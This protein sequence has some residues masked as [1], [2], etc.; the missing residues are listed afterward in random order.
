[1]G[2]YLATC[3]T[4]SILFQRPIW[5]SLL[6]C[7]PQD[8]IVSLTNALFY[9]CKTEVSIFRTKQCESVLLSEGT[10]CFS[11]RMWTAEGDIQSLSL[12]ISCIIDKC[13]ET[14]W[15]HE[16]LWRGHLDS[17]ASGAHSCQRERGAFLFPLGKWLISAKQSKVLIWVK[18]EQPKT[19]ITGFRL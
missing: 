3:W 7:A 2:L 4:G 19:T 5:K 13:S 14:L 15:T 18:R 1:M 11:V 16:A 17:K 8:S 6:L 10:L 9:L 12:H